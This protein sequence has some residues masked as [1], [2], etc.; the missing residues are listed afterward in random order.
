MTKTTSTSGKDDS[1]SLDLEW[2]D[3]EGMNPMLPMIQRSKTEEDI[4]QE[5]LTCRG[6][7]PGSYPV[8]TS[9]NS[10]R[11]AWESDFVSASG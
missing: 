4:L 7:K 6:K 2:E 11:L 10:N 1:T 3:E 9:D 8:S 5:L